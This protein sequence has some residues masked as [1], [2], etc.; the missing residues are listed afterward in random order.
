MDPERQLG[1]PPPILFV[2]F[3]KTNCQK[4]RVGD[5]YNIKILD[6]PLLFKV[7]VFEFRYQTSHEELKDK[8]PKSLDFSVKYFICKNSFNCCIS[9]V[10]IKN[11]IVC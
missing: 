9:T 7:N 11:L 2:G 8:L 6:L 5:P 10:R 3:F 4:Y 1:T